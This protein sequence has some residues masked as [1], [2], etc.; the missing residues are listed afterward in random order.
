MTTVAERSLNRFEEFLERVIGA[1]RLQLA[2]GKLATAFLD[3]SQ[4]DELILNEFIDAFT[5]LW[6]SWKLQK[7]KHLISPFIAEHGRSIFKIWLNFVFPFDYRRLDAKSAKGSSMVD[8][9]GSISY[10]YTP[11]ERQLIK[12]ICEKYK[13]IM[14]EKDILRILIT[15]AIKSLDATISKIIE[16]SYRLFIDKIDFMEQQDNLLIKVEIVGRIG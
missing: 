11:E 10:T 16:T 6:S 9:L 5:P 14:S 4:R 7:G 3:E 1:S 15:N 8:S 2:G 13:T 12:I